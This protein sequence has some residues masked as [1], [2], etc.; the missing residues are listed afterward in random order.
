LLTCP[1]NIKLFEFI[2]LILLRIPAGLQERP[3]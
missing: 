3:R 1:Y 2:L